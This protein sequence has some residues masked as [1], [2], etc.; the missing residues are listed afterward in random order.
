MNKSDPPDRPD[1]ERALREWGRRPPR[2]SPEAAASRVVRRLAAPTVSRR[3][4]RLAWVAA[5]ITVVAAG[6]WYAVRNGG[7]GLPVTPPAAVADVA[8]MPLGDNVVLWWLDEETPVYF[9]LDGSEHEERRDD[10]P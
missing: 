3:L 9:V 2:T 6:T 7:D 10:N 1:F 8:A 5:T 4:P